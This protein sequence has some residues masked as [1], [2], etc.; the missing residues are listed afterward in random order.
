M[1]V[2]ILAVV[3]AHQADAATLR[4]R[5]GSQRTVELAEL[6][7][8]A[9]GQVEELRLAEPPPSDRW[10]LG[11]LVQTTAGDS[12]RTERLR[13]RHDRLLI[14]TPLAGLSELPLHA[15][16]LIWLTPPATLPDATRREIERTAA[17]TLRQDTVFVRKE[18]E[19]VTVD[20]V[21]QSL[22]ENRAVFRWQDGERE[23]PLT[24]AA[25]IA[26]AGSRPPS[27]PRE[28]L[29]A[30]H[31][32]DGSR[33]VGALRSWAA[34]AAVLDTPA[35]GAV[36][37]P[38]DGVAVLDAI[39]GRSEFVSDME[40]AA[41]NEAGYYG[42]KFPWRRNAS[43]FGGPLTMRGRVFERGLGVHSRSS[44]AYRL[45]KK[46]ALLAGVIGLNDGASALGHVEFVVRG[47]GKELFRAPMAAG[48]APRPLRVSVAGVDMLELF[49]DFGR[50]E[51]TGDHANWVELRLVK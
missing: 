48:D 45:D 9:V 19:W 44:L 33:L 4:W 30:V 18:G 31:G 14:E 42:T 16:A 41:V 23:I 22:D 43:V 5:D 6:A 3:V 46:F 27:A 24:L 50:N 2:S 21:L 40:P 51:D 15:V 39:W 11:Y 26:L 35:L 13:L 37:V 29:A 49:V 8:V 10:R 38:L 47:D 36:T 34:D 20:G 25:A 12:L 17:G 28:T 32:C 7:K 1:A